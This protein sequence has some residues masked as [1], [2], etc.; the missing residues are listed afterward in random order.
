MY[1]VPRENALLET[2]LSDT[3]GERAK[4]LL[5]RHVAESNKCKA[6]SISAR[7]IP[8]RVFGSV[9]AMKV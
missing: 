2:F 1:R 9:L 4:A 8:L 5:D 7:A 6:L 3:D